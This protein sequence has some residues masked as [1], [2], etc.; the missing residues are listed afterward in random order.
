MDAPC[1]L[2]EQLAQHVRVDR[3]CC[4]CCRPLLLLLMM[5]ENLPMDT[6]GAM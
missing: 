1:H 4:H 2:S 5:Q 3:L 6:K